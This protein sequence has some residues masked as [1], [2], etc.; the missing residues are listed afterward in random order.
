LS[1]IEQTRRTAFE[2]SS[3]GRAGRE[4][5]TVSLN[6]TV[7]DLDHILPEEMKK[8][9][10]RIGNELILSHEDGLTAIAIATEHQIAVLGF[11]LGEVLDDGFRVVDYSGYEYKFSGAW[12]AFVRTNNGEA[13]RWS[14]EHRLGQNHGYI[15]TST[16]EREFANLRQRNTQ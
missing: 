14:K 11:E 7:G 13:E 9:A 1:W 4:G 6:G 15:V 10:V 12:D 5:D 2:Q 3:Y 8:R 16:S